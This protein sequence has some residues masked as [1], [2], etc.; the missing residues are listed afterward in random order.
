[1]AGIDITRIHTRSIDKDGTIYETSFDEDGTAHEQQIGWQPPCVEHDAPYGR[2]RRCHQIVEPTP[3]PEPDFDQIARAIAGDMT[4]QSTRSVESDDVA[5]IAEQL[6]LVW[7]AR[8]AADIAT[9]EN[10]LTYAYSS[11]PDAVIVKLLDR[12]LRHL[13]R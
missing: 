4:A 10:T 7:N 5:A 12:A 13:D 2:C 8:G 9:I 3:M 11:S 1:M 6:R